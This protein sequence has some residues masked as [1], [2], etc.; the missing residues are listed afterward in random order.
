MTGQTSAAVPVMKTSS[1]WMSVREPKATT[2]PRVTIGTMA[3]R[4]VI[5]HDSAR[6]AAAGGFGLNGP[7]AAV[8]VHIVAN[9]LLICRCSVPLVDAGTK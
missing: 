3:I 2:K 5:A 6:A 1:A 9:R 4:P 8:S 7:K